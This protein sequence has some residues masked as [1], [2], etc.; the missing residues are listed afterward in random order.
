MRHVTTIFNDI[1]II[2][3]TFVLSRDHHGSF[4][5]HM[6]FLREINDLIKR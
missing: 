2:K 4:N 1:T 3:S 6:Q 5:M